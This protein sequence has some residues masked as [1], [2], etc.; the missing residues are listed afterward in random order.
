MNLL[1]NILKLIKL[2]FFLLAGGS[3]KA[4]GP[5]L[6]SIII[7]SAEEPSPLFVRAKPEFYR[8][9]SKIIEHQPILAQ[10]NFFKKKSFIPIRYFYEAVIPSFETQAKLSLV[11]IKPIFKETTDIF[12]SNQKCRTPYANYEFI[13]NNFLGHIEIYPQGKKD[14]KLLF[15]FHNGEYI[16]NF[17]EQFHLNQWTVID[18]YRSSALIKLSL[19]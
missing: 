13:N 1:K 5:Y 4:H 17:S 9:Q 18:N 16:L 19:L 6:L 11:K 8:Y 15:N 2:N 3:L 10:K 14:V 7:L 12:F